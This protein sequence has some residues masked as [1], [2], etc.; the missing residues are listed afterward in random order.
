[1][2]EAEET[3]TC[4]LCNLAVGQQ[5][6]TRRFDDQERRFCCLGCMN[7]YTIL[8]ESGVIAS[9][10]ELRETELFKRSL[11]L[12]LIATGARQGLQSGAEIPEGTPTREALLQVSG[13]WCSSCAWLIEEALR[14]ERGVVSAE[15]FFASDLVKIKYCPQFLP[16]ERLTQRLEN[17]GYKASEY[18]GDQ[19]LA[20][21]E[22]RDL[23]L[24]FGIAGF[25]WLNLMTLSVAL[26]VGYFE[27]I[28]DS[29]SRFLPFVL[30]ALATPVIVYSAQPILR[31]AWQGLVNRTVRM[32][33]LLGLGILAAYAYSAVQAFRGETHVYF[34]T[35]SA[36]VTLVLLGKLLERTARERTARAI[37]LLYRMMPRKVRLMSEGRENFVSIEALQIGDIFLVK[38]GERAPAD[39]LVV[40]GN[41]HMDE[42]LLTGESA[43]ISKKAGSPILSGS[44]N[45]GNAIQVKATKACTD[46]TLARVIQLVEQALISRSSLERTVDRAAKLFVPAVIGIAALTFAIC[47]MSGATNLG[48]ALMRAIT[49]LVIACPCALG[50]ATPLAITAAI[51][52]ASRRG[53]LV[54]DSRVLETIRQVDTVVFD[55]TGTITEGDFSLLEV[56]LYRESALAQTAPA[57]DV[58]G[59]LRARQVV[60]PGAAEDE[61]AKTY[62]LSLIASLERYS[63]HP[64]GRAFMKAAE[65][66]GCE[67]Q[68]ATEVHNHKGQGMTGRVATKQ[69]F[70]GNRRLLEGQ[71]ACLDANCEAR[72]R[73]AEREGYTV[74]F[75]GF[76]EGVEGLLIFGDRVKAEAHTVIQELRR[77]GIRTLVVSGDAPETT[78]TIAQ[79]V[80]ADDFIAGALP[81]E[82]TAI[83]QRL[84][85]S[86]QVVA[87]IGDG[88]NDAPALAS[89]DLG[90]AMGSG[91][92]MAMR[93]ASIVLMG[94]GLGKVL[95]CFAIARKAWRVVRQNLFW[96]FLYNTLGISLAVTGL[97][98]PIMA[99]GAMLLSSL[100]VIGNSLRL[101]AKLAAKE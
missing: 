17:L 49:V 59:N 20:E 8:L 30:L 67:L 36:I 60:K 46:S 9:G 40:E 23:L 58:R 19:T 92:D 24:R 48:E 66:F 2:R 57:N 53:I 10:Q 97:L 4:E 33:S 6:F 75:F 38:A 22:R 63:E 15:V 71:G 64:L 39:G 85:E 43:P 81:D 32:E 100:S 29:L 3:A 5:P 80:G 56:R 27:R 83:I 91:T 25:L 14:N 69:V 44:I 12:G 101:S 68:Q 13:M 51:G 77:Q 61:F 62:C 89:A 16:P 74:A 99:A 86:G 26:Y 72:A 35:A 88:I 73:Q 45:T 87:M 31:L 96:A 55:K 47:W 1:M 11:R 93:A 7:V 90:I 34:D 52:A 79:L 28:N 70:V 42:S 76:D 78:Q 98:N 84:Q 54:S 82:K 21:A 65:R 37:T 95:E 41:T 18:T 94:N 50:M